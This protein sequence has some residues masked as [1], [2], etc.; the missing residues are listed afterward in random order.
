[1][2]TLEGDA[3]SEQSTSVGGVTTC[4]S[5]LVTHSHYDPNIAKINAQT[6]AIEHRQANNQTLRRKMSTQDQTTRKPKTEDHYQNKT[7]KCNN[8]IKE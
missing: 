6:R 3:H 2:E 1:M 7:P 8:K 4:T 5:L